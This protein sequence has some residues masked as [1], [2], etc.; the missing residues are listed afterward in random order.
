[1]DAIDLVIGSG[2]VTGKASKALQVRDGDVE[3]SEEPLL[4]SPLAGSV[5][6]MIPMQSASDSPRDWAPMHYRC[7]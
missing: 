5:T 7:H 1:M 6:T 2:S 4:A 3:D